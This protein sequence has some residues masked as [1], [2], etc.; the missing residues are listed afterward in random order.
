MSNEDEALRNYAGVM[1]L[2]KEVKAYV[3]PRRIGSMS[4]CFH[5]IDLEFWQVRRILYTCE[6]RFSIVQHQSHLTLYRL[7]IYRCKE[8]GLAA[9]NLYASGDGD[10]ES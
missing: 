10:L 6:S 2:M 3:P 9:L 1:T 8:G 5:K 7:R 4:S